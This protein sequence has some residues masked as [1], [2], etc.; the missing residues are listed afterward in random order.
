MGNVVHNP[1]NS[2]VRKR[3]T[4]KGKCPQYDVVRMFKILVLQHL[5]NL[6]KNCENQICEKRL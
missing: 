2:V 1:K 5:Y 4:N 3:I 6:Q